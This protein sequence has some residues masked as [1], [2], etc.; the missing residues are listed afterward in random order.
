M[1]GVVLRLCVVITGSMSPMKG[2]IIGRLRHRLI[3]T[4]SY[5]LC[6]SAR[7]G[8]CASAAGTRRASAVCMSAHLL[9]P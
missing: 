9:R 2:A 1:R 6:E 5:G 8:R 4:I 7:I 3:L